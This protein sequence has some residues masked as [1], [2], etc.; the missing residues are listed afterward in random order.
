MDL[1]YND[2]DETSIVKKIYKWK[3][4]TSTPKSR[5]EDDVRKDLKR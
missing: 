1:E 2:N 5:W 4:F 3:P